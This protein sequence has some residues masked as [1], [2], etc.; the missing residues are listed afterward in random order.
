MLKR[1]LFLCLGLWLIGA[2]V[3][4]AHAREC[5]MSGAP[6][7]VAAEEAHAHCD[8]MGTA[9]DDPLPAEPDQPDEAANC[10]CPAVLANIAGPAGLAAGPDFGL[11]EG[12]TADPRAPSRTLIPEPPP[13]KA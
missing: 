5:G 4:S 6:E 2:S 12:Y 9:T 11:P 13:P 3:F 8:M 10:C 7:A 1:A